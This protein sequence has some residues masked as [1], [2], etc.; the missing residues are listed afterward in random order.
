MKKLDETLAGVFQD[1][2]KEAR[3]E[4]EKILDQKLGGEVWYQ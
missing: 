4:D 3:H 2:M 1:A